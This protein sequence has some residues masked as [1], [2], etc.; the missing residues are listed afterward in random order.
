MGC[1]APV[2]GFIKS[3]KISLESE[4]WGNFDRFFSLLTTPWQA[5]G[6]GQWRRKWEEREGEREGGRNKI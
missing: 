4:N 1:T 3:S 2:L 5:Q 6:G